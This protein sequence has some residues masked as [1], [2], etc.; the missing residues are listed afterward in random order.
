MPVSL[1]RDITAQP[2]HYI[3]TCLHL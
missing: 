2:V 1:Q 3:H